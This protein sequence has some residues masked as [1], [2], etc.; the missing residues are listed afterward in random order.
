MINR[1]EL[2]V[3]GAAVV[4]AG[5][6]PGALGAFEAAGEPSRELF[7]SLVRHK[8]YVFV[9]G[10]IHR[11]R[12]L[13]VNEWP[14]QRGL[15]QFALVLLGKRRRPIPEGLYDVWNR[16]IGWFSLYIQPLEAPFYTAVFGLL[17]D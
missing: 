17:R 16:R 1:R 12:L 8:F 3:G 7:L 13:E 14:S 2:M 15:E 5:L 4:A 10:R 11:V 9:S 6:I